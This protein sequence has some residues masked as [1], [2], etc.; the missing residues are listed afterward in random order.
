MGQTVPSLDDVQEVGHLPVRCATLVNLASRAGLLTVDGVTLEEGDR[1]LVKNQS[2]PSQNGVYVATAGTWGRAEDLDEGTPQ[3]GSAGASFY[4]Q[5]GTLNAERTFT[6]TTSGD[7][8]VGT[9]SITF[10][11]LDEQGTARLLKDENLSV[12]VDGITSAFQVSEDFAA[13]S[14]WVFRNGQKLVRDVHFAVTGDDTFLLDDVPQ[15]GDVIEVAYQV[16]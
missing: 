3:E 11:D 14:L 10:E 8:T 2:T 12:Q 15:L 4:V 1:I 7:I 16:P 6:L 9:T 13:D 5:E